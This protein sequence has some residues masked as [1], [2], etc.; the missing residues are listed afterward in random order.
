MTGSVYTGNRQRSKKRASNSMLEI[1]TSI[2][3][4][5]GQW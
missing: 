1:C 3:S 4:A 5:P 2:A